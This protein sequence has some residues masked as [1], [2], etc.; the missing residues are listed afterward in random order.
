MENLAKALVSLRTSLKNPK[1]ASK[2]Y[3]WKYAD[4]VEVTESINESLI[5]NK[6]TVVQMP[7]SSLQDGKALMGVKTIVMHESGETIEN[8]FST[9]LTDL[10]PKGVGGF[11]TYYRRYA[12]LAIFGLAPEEEIKGEINPEHNKN[13]V[14]ANKQIS[15]KQMKLLRE[16]HDKLNPDEVE[17]LKLKTMDA[18]EASTIIGRILGSKK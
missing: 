10:D 5:E 7:I 9:P 8:E 1:K 2:G 12:L 3:N 17:R 18:T 6:L 11:I 15:D 16:N 14:T 4:L 13:K